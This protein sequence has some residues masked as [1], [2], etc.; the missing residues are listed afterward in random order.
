MAITMIFLFLWAEQ[1]V[2]TFMT[3]HLTEK[4]GLPLAMAAVI[5]GA[6]GITGWI[7][8]V[9]WGTLSDH[10]GRK[11]SLRII[12]G[13][14]ATVIAMIFINSALTGWVILIG[15]GLFAICPTQ[16]LTLS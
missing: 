10:L 12:V 16:W 2:A 3:L 14:I 11:F 5:S 8:Q 15:W 13:W 7:G 4:V 1:G 6:S 9:V